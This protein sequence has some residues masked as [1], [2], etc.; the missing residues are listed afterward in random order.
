M[1][2]QTNSMSALNA[3]Q[4]NMANKIIVEGIKAGEPA[5]VI[6]AAVLIAF[7]ES[8]LG[9]RLQ[10]EGHSATGVFQFQPASWQPLWNNFV[11]ANPD[12][13]LSSLS[14]ADAIKNPNAQIQ[15]MYKNLDKWYAGYDEGSLARNYLPGPNPGHEL[16]EDVTVPLQNSG[17]DILTNFLDY[18][19]LRHNTTVDQTTTIINSNYTSENLGITSQ[20]IS[21]QIPSSFAGQQSSSVS[22]DGL[23]VTTD[24]QDDSGAVIGQD[25]QSYTDA[26]RTTLSSEVV[27]EK[28]GSNGASTTTTTTINYNSDGSSCTFDSTVTDSN[29]SAVLSSFTGDQD[30]SGSVNGSVSGNNADVNVSG[31]NL[32]IADGGSATVNGSH[33]DITA[34]SD[35][36]VNL[37]NDSD[38]DVLT[39]MKNGEVVLA[40][41]D[42]DIEVHAAGG[43]VAM[44]TGNGVAI[45]GDNVKVTGGDNNQVTTQGSDEDVTLG[46]G[47]TLNVESGSATANLSDSSVDIAQGA[48]ATIAGSQDTVG[49]GANDSVSLA[50]GSDNDVLTLDGPG[51][52]TIADGDVGEAISASGSTLS[53]GQGVSATL[54]GSTD[55]FGASNDT[56]TLLGS[57]YSLSGAGDLIWA[58]NAALNISNYNGASDVI[59]GDDN[60]VNASWSDVTLN[61]TNGSLTGTY[62][63]LGLTGSGMSVSGDYNTISFG[64]GTT[65]TVSSYG[66]SINLGAGSSLTSNGEGDN[67]IFATSDD[68]LVLGSTWGT[69]S[70]YMDTLHVSD[71]QNITLGSGSAFNVI[72]SGNTL[73]AGAGDSLIASNDAISFAGSGD[74]VSGS[75]DVIVASNDTL[76]ISNYNA[77]S[78]VINGDNNTVNAS[79]SDV[80]LNGASESVTGTYDVLQMVGSGDAVFGDWNSI[81]FDTTADAVES[82]SGSSNTINF[83][84]GTT[85]TVTGS[86]DTI[87]LEAGSNLSGSG[88][89]G[90][91]IYA[92]SDDVLVLDGAAGNMGTLHVSDD[93]NITLGGNS[94]FNVIGSGNTLN[95]GAGDSLIAS[96]DAIN[97]AG[98]GGSVSG[99]GDV[100][101]ASNDTLTISNYNA[102]SDVINGDNNTVNAS[103]SDVTLNGASGS[104]TGTYDVLQMVG[105]GDAVVGDWNS[106][107]FDTTADAVESVSGSSNT[108]NFGARTTATVTGSNDTINLGAGSSLTGSGGGGDTIY[109]T[110]DDVLVLD[111]AAGNM[112]T[113]HVSDDQNITLGGNSA[114][115]VVG[116]G[117]TLNAGTGD[118]LVASNDAI[119]F[120]GSGGSVSGSGDMIT[121]SNQMIGVSNYNAPSDVITGDNNTVNASWSD[122]TLNGANES[123][124]GT[125]DVLALAGAGE[126]VA[127]DWNSISFGAGTTAVVTGGNEAINLGEDSTLTSNGGGGNTIYATSDDVLSLGSTAGTAS[128]YMDTLHVS[129]DQNITLGSNSTFNVIGSGNTLSAGAGDSLIANSDVISFSGSSG[130]VSGA[131]NMISANNATLSIS[132]YNA[133]SDVITGDNN[134]INASWSDVTLNGTNGSVVGT[135]DV[136]ALSGSGESVSGDWNSIS[137]AAGTKV[138]VS[139]SQNVVT[140]SSGEITLTGDNSSLVVHGDKDNFAVTGVNDRIIDDRADGTSVIYNWSGSGVETDSVY[141][142]D[143]GTG[144][145]IGGYGY[146]G[147]G[148]GEDLPGSYGGGDDGGGYGFAGTQSLVSSRM[149]TNIG[150]I[151][152][153]DLSH[154][155]FSAAESAEAAQQQAASTAAL[156][157]TAGSGS[158]VLEGAKWDQQVITWSLAD[159]A[160]TQ[161]APFSGYMGSA[162][163]T[164]VQ[165]AFGA[166]ANAMPGV[167]FEEVADSSQSDIRIGFGD[168][169]TA[170]TGVVGYTSYQAKAGQLES[171]TII[172]VEDTTQDALTTGA[173]G[174]Q[175]YTGTDAT[176]SQVL[177]HEIGHALGLAD[178]ADQ[179]SV[180]N[181]QLTASN[182]TLDQTDLVGIGSLYGDGSST[183]PVG[184][185][186][187]SQLIQAMSTFSADGGVA[188]TTLLPPSLADQKVMLSASSHAA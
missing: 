72:G 185:S 92:T 65:A 17:I 158:A 58:S 148:P 6:Q 9:E 25:V 181:Y 74:S 18:S 131:G 11:L 51:T 186:G 86:N 171:D 99:S 136:L 141:S 172:R 135:Y 169:D 69:A 70:P 94:A 54:Y 137:L 153:Y 102:P 19:Y 114:F 164:V 10:T 149:G 145:I 21:S 107:S 101:A 140:G 15:I 53:L 166:W 75:G 96:N 50:S 155:H 119:S 134:T 31:A 26:N 161:A 126:S 13:P 128:P 85:A 104:V 170:S 123:V 68:A 176:L 160:G 3:N 111:G 43:S 167:T 20:M 147:T 125:Y 4:L 16:Y 152:Q 127:G 76:T 106:I 113:L 180:M 97:F 46:N 177:E 82:V 41:A 122:V 108:I 154:G 8:S 103:W 159:G 60:T 118:L 38:W 81:N 73:N 91:T 168:F 109:A 162:E 88:A 117:N 179:N 37:S 139:G 33:N 129:D 30:N 35:S 40:S 56:L 175:T 116:G 44:G 143:D 12:N 124:V 98:S 165:A 77:P 173:A 100:I 138:S 142:G 55:N 61:G 45:D 7:S 67:T 80:T 182:R 151:A 188:D 5:V 157:P 132:N 57:G 184:G 66:D 156:T 36:K 28:D 84:A 89:G 78:D 59:T 79:W 150:S 146:T 27:T 48:K 115:N 130:S 71:D 52:V 133:A 14:A 174:Q 144:D 24:I 105:S 121:A 1:S 112:E 34:G 23:T 95:A 93:Q 187:V 62:D 83:D 87:N 42:D 110:S 163:E 63:V 47:S 120:A 183:A 64:A 22:A 178:N 2:T 90:D 29:T 32:A 39:M 49:V